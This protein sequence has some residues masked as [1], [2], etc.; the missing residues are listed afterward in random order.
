MKVSILYASVA[1]LSSRSTFSTIG[2]IPASAKQPFLI[3]L[4]RNTEAP[5]NTVRDLLE[6][7]AGHII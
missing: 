4:V 6:L 1:T 3:P 5:Y 2:Y 7:S